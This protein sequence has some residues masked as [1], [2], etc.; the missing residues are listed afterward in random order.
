MKIQIEKEITLDEV[1]G[2]IVTALEGGSN[3]WYWV[4]TEDF[5]D[6]LP[7]P[8]KPITQRISKAIYQDPSF[9]MPVYDVEDKDEVLGILSQKSFKEGLE[10][11]AKDYPD[12]L[13]AIFNESYDAI[14]ADVIFQLC[15][16]QDVVFG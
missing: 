2:I 1:E 13:D 7:D 11:A 3:Y 8:G 15:V 5:K 12:R 9:R 14:D 4:K 6:D 16:M 10:L